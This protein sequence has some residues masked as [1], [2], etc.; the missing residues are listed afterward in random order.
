MWKRKKK[1]KKAK[2]QNKNRTEKKKK[3][4]QNEEKRHDQ[5]TNE[6]AN[7]KVEND[8]K[9]IVQEEEKKMVEDSEKKLSKSIKEEE[10]E[11]EKKIH[12]G[13]KI[14]KKEKEEEKGAIN[15]LLQEEIKE[16][17][18]EKQVVQQDE[19][20]KMK[21]KKNEEQQN[22]Q[23]DIADGELNKINA[24]QKDDKHL[25]DTNVYLKHEFDKK[26]LLIIDNHPKYKN[27]SESKYYMQAKK[28]FIQGGWSLGKERFCFIFSS[29]EWQQRGYELLKNYYANDDGVV[30]KQVGPSSESEID[31]Q[32]LLDE[33]QQL[34]VKFDEKKNYCPEIVFHHISRIRIR[35]FRNNGHVSPDIDLRK[36]FL[37]NLMNLIQLVSCS[38]TSNTGYS[39]VYDEWIQEINILL[40][41]KSS[42]FE[43][44]LR[45]NEQEAQQK[46]STNIDQ[47]VQEIEQSKEKKIQ[48]T[49]REKKEELQMAEKNIEQEKQS[50][51]HGQQKESILENESSDNESAEV[52]EKNIETNLA[53]TCAY[54]IKLSKIKQEMSREHF[55]TKE[56][57][58]L[59]L[60][61]L[62][63]PPENRGMDR[64]TYRKKRKL[65]I[66]K[67]L[68]DK[69]I[70]VSSSLIT[71]HGFRL[72][73]NSEEDKKRAAKECVEFVRNEALR[74][75]ERSG[76]RREKREH[77][78][79]RSSRHLSS[80]SNLSSSSTLVS[81]DNRRRY[82]RESRRDRDRYDRE[83]EKR[84]R[85]HYEN[86]RFSER[87]RRES[88][89][90][91]KRGRDRRDDGYHDSRRRYEHSSYDRR[92]YHDSRR[93]RDYYNRSHDKRPRPSSPPRSRRYRS[94]TPPR[95]RP[96]SPPPRRRRMRS[97]SPPIR[98]Y[99]HARASSNL[100]HNTQ[101]YT[102]SRVPSTLPPAR[103]SYSRSRTS[104]PSSSSYSR[105]RTSGKS[106]SPPVY[107]QVSQKS[108]PSPK[109]NSTPLTDPYSSYTQRT[110]AS[111]Y[112]LSRTPYRQSSYNTPGIANAHIMGQKRLK[113]SHQSNMKTPKSR[114]WHKGLHVEISVGESHSIE[115]T[116]DGPPK[117]DYY[118]V[119]IGNDP[120]YRMVAKDNI[121]PVMFSA[122]R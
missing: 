67:F 115:G 79:S 22:C 5:K 1:F 101:S 30:L 60:H 3:K 54:E 85:R 118:P 44:P 78:S 110:S 77:S 121:R 65:D 24:Q 82:H 122:R 32:L 76:D 80:S 68:H 51:K 43:D 47:K 90:E 28:I 46:S 104:T 97:P 106:Y 49:E 8:E 19:Q 116:I 48:D 10:K 35:I 83:R 72:T 38:S 88:E 55:F 52:K 111:S 27:F 9:K 11:K 63:S 2:K 14:E 117:G 120:N 45:T 86:Y 69:D 34:K 31:P 102:R 42:E 98:S 62:T 4:N 39:T 41:G 25:T 74:K 15:S 64:E 59:T 71:E 91:G 56:N 61:M 99:R 84:D 81:R 93:D 112:P 7:A 66:Q 21:E 33:L 26:Y 29:K 75:T 103:S 89:K 40:Q 18:I 108:H 114:Y 53:T 23:P 37:L 58:Q 100:S 107:S 105:A 87:R 73:F 36:K 95:R 119:I 6:E 57:T 50:S 12:E 92:G 113:T 16:K 96:P 13:I 17:N 94:P 109:Y 70:M 20:Q